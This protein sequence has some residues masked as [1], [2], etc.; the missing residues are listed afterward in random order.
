MSLE[1]LNVTTQ[2]ILFLTLV[3]HT[4]YLVKILLNIWSVGYIKHVK[5]MQTER[6]I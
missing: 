6:L 2:Y 4:I 1:W 3:Q 5:I